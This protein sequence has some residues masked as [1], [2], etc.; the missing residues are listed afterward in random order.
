MQTWGWIVI[1]IAAALLIVLAAALVQIRRRR[2]HLKERFGSEYYR[3]VSEQG[4]SSGEKHLSQVEHEREKLTIRPLPTAARERFLEEWRSAEGRFVSDP[5]EATRTAERIVERALDERGYPHGDD[6]QAENGRAA[7][8]AVDHADVVERY[9]HGHAMLE[10]VEGNE[11]TENLRKAML[12]FRAVL[13][14][15]LD[16]TKV[17]A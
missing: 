1:A 13:D 15:L 16:T 2:S 3:T 8:V 11:G 7:V 10:K 5:R 9:R 4:T 6:T 12:D 17:T 14:E